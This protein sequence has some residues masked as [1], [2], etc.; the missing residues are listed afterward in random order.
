MRFK[1]I[2]FI[3]ILS[4]LL[5]G[6]AKEEE[7][8]GLEK[9]EIIPPILDLK[10]QAPPGVFLTVNGKEFKAKEFRD[11]FEGV[12]N[13]QKDSV[14]KGLRDEYKKN[15]KAQMIERLIM[16]TLIE[17]EAK[18]KQVTVSN[19]EIDK[20]WKQMKASFGDEKMW[21]DFVHRT[22]I[23]KGDMATAILMT[24]LVEKELGPNLNPTDKEIRAYYDNH[25][26]NF[27]KPERAHVRH[28]L[29]AVEEKEDEFIRRSKREKLEAI[30]QEILKGKDFA[31]AAR[32]YS[33]CP[34]KVRGGDLGEVFRP[35]EEDAL[36][37]AIFGQKI[38]E[39]GPIVESKRGF[40]LVQVLDRK[41]RE[42]VPFAQVK[43]QIGEMLK[44]GRMNEAYNLLS[45]RLRKD[46]VIIKF[47]DP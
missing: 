35:K 26:D 2:C 47:Y 33:D 22:G 41:P 27:T 1:G 44:K 37:R 24:K 28:I 42:K 15:L 40:H 7:K 32:E 20:E 18:R 34:S 36:S 45:A 23:E 10:K 39:V 16:K 17:E 46:A 30:R 21:N 31:Q 43:D 19:E 5:F 38:G 25:L 13:R 8:K 12:W 6:C 11:N 29:M 9:A 4:V 3:L 14:P